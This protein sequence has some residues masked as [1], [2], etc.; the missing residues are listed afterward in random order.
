LFRSRIALCYAIVFAL[1][2]APSFAEEPGPLRIISHLPSLTEIAFELGLGDNVVGVSGF[3]MYPRQVASIPKVGGLIDTNFEAI[4][5]LRPTL[6]LLD[7]S[8]P[9][10]QKKYR[11]LGVKTVLTSPRS[12]EGIYT[13]IQAV[14]EATDRNEQAEALVKRVKA[15]IAAV[16]GKYAGEKKPSTLVIVGHNPGSLDGLFAA[17]T[18]SYHDELLA[19]AGG[20][21]CLTTKEPYLSLSKEWVVRANPEVIVVLDPNGDGSAEGLAREKKV[22]GALSYLK[23]VKNDR[24]CHLTGDAVSQSGPRMAK[25]A[26]AIGKCVHPKTE[27]AKP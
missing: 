15:E 12:V 14:G 5:A 19:I 27:D 9:E 26:E 11:K 25:L 17:G 4:V 20:K 1:V 6:A 21:N 7:D 23:A 2:C 13:T 3:E 24:V 18:N 22:W 10:H 16:R 8:M